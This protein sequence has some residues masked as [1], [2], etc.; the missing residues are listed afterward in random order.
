MNAEYYVYTYMREDGT[1]YY[2]GKGKNNRAYAKGKGE[3]RPPK[4][5]HRIV[6][7]KQNLSEQEAFDLEITLINEYGRKDLDTGILRNKTNGGDGASGIIRTVEQSLAQSLRQL[8]KKISKH[9]VETNLAKSKRQL[10]KTQS[11][12]LVEKRVASLRGK[13]LTT[14][15]KS[16]IS[17]SKLG[18]ARTEESRKKQSVTITGRK[19]PE[20]STTLLGK[21][22]PR[23]QCPHCTKFGGINNMSRWHFDSCKASPQ[24]QIIGDK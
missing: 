18:S 12:T 15:H 21:A 16:K 13:S 22:R 5:K 9:S 11:A 6:I 10:G 1:P 20:H 8:N 3:V 7:I 14:E 23:V 24:K 17:V 2:V 19:R 4:D